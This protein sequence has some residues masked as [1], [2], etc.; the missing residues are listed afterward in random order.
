[1]AAEINI[2]DLFVTPEVGVKPPASGAVSYGGVLGT[3]AA[4][5]HE[6]VKPFVA[7]IEIDDMFVKQEPVSLPVVSPLPSPTV[8]SILS[9]PRGTG[10]LANP[11]NVDTSKFEPAKDPVA[12]ASIDIDDMFE[13]PKLPTVPRVS[14]S[15][16]GVLG[17]SGADV[18]TLAQAMQP[19]QEDP[20]SKMEQARI[21]SFNKT[22]Q[23][24]V[25]QKVDFNSTEQL[26]QIGEHVAKSIREDVAKKGDAASLKLLN[27]TKQLFGD[28]MWV[29]EDTH[30]ALPVSIMMSGVYN[31]QTA[32]E[33]SPALRSVL[34]DQRK[35]ARFLDLLPQGKEGQVARTYMATLRDTL[36]KYSRGELDDTTGRKMEEMFRSF[37]S[38]AASTLLGVFVAPAITPLGGIAVSLGANIALQ[39]AITQNVQ[40]GTT[41]GLELLGKGFSKAKIATIIRDKLRPEYVA[42]DGTVLRDKVLAAKSPA[43]GTGQATSPYLDDTFGRAALDVLTGQGAIMPRYGVVYNAA[44]L[45]GDLIGNALA[46]VVV[47]AVSPKTTLANMVIKYGAKVIRDMGVNVGAGSAVAAA[48]STDAVQHS[49]VSWAEEDDSRLTQIAKQIAPMFLTGAAGGKV[50]DAILSQAG[51]AGADFTVS[52]LAKTLSDMDSTNPTISKS[53]NAFAAFAKEFESPTLS[54]RQ[55]VR[56][57]ASA[58]GSG[59][60]PKDPGVQ[61]ETLINAYDYLFNLHGETMP[62]EQIVSWVDALPA[63]TRLAALMQLSELAAPHNVKQEFVVV[64]DADGQD[65]L[66]WQTSLIPEKTKF[67]VN[68]EAMS[69][70]PQRPTDLDEA[71]KLSTSP[72]KLSTDE[73]AKFVDI[74]SSGSQKTQ[75]FVD[76]VTKLSDNEILDKAFREAGDDP[77]RQKLVVHLLNRALSPASKKTEAGY[78]LRELMNTSDPATTLALVSKYTDSVVDPI[79]FAQLAVHAR[80]QRSTLQ[81]VYRMPKYLASVV[82]FTDN[83]IDTIK[84]ATYDTATTDLLKNMVQGLLV[85]TAAKYKDAGIP[86]LITKDNGVPALHEDHAAYVQ[87]Y[88]SK[89]PKFDS[90]DWFAAMKDLVATLKASIN[91]NMKDKTDQER[92]VPSIDVK[93]IDLPVDPQAVSQFGQLLLL[94]GLDKQVRS[95]PKQ[96]DAKTFVSK[97][98]LA[99]KYDEAKVFDQVKKIVDDYVDYGSASVYNRLKQVYGES[100]AVPISVLRAFRVLRGYGQAVEKNEMDNTL[101]VSLAKIRQ[102][103]SFHIIPE[104]YRA[105]FESTPEGVVALRNGLVNTD[106]I[107]HN[108]E[109][110]LVAM[111]RA[112]DIIRREALAPVY[113]SGLGPIAPITLLNNASFW[114]SKLTGD[115]VAAAKG[116]VGPT[117]LAFGTSPTLLKT[118][119]NALTTTINPS[120]VGMLL[121]T[122]AHTS[123]PAGMAELCHLPVSK[124][125]V[126]VN[127]LLLLDPEMSERFRVRV[128]DILNTLL[129]KDNIKKYES[130]EPFES[131]AKGTGSIRDVSLSIIGEYINQFRDTKTPGSTN[132]LTYAAQYLS[133]HPNIDWRALTTDLDMRLKQAYMDLLTSQREFDLHGMQAD[134]LQ[135]VN[136]HGI[137]ELMKV[138][139]LSRQFQYAVGHLT[140]HLED[141]DMPHLRKMF[142]APSNATKT[143][144]I[145]RINDRAKT[146]ASATLFQNAGFG[147]KEALTSSLERNFFTF[148]GAQF[149][150]D[151]VVALDTYNEL[152]EQLNQ[153]IYDPTTA[154][155]TP[156]AVKGWI[157]LIDKLR[158]IT[159]TLLGQDGSL[160]QF[161]SLEM[162]ELLRK[163]SLNGLDIAYDLLRAFDANPKMYNLGFTTLQSAM[164]EFS[165]VFDHTYG[166]LDIFMRN[167][168][169]DSIAQGGSLTNASVM[170]SLLEPLGQLANTGLM[171]H[172]VKASVYQLGR[173]T[174]YKKLT[175]RIAETWHNLLASPRTATV[176]R[177]LVAPNYGYSRAY[178]DLSMQLSR[179]QDNLDSQVQIIQ[180]QLVRNAQLPQEFLST[181]KQFT[182][183]DRDT[184]VAYLTTIFSQAD[185]NTPSAAKDILGQLGSNN[186]RLPE[187]IQ[188]LSV[189][190]ASTPAMKSYEDLANQLG[191]KV[192]WMADNDKYHSF[193]DP[194]TS[195]M[196]LSLRNGQSWSPRY[197]LGHELIHRMQQ[198][199]PRKFEEFMNT[200]FQVSAKDVQEFRDR[201][202]QQTGT[203][204][205]GTDR[206][207]T[208][209]EVKVEMLAR[210][211]GELLAQPDFA[212]V[213]NPGMNK[214][215]ADT[216]AME[217]G[218]PAPQ[219]SAPTRLTSG[220]QDLLHSY[221]DV[222]RRH[223]LFGFEDVQDTRSIQRANQF[224]DL[225]SKYSSAGILDVF[226]TAMLSPLQTAVGKKIKYSALMNVEDF[227]ADAKLYEDLIRNL[228]A[229]IQGKPQFDS[230]SPQEVAKLTADLAMDFTGSILSSATSDLNVLGMLERTSPS[231]AVAAVKLRAVMS[232]VSMHAFHE[233]QITA[234]DLAENPDYLPWQYYYAGAA[235]KQ[236][237]MESP[238][239]VNRMLSLLRMY[240]KNYEVQVKSKV[241]DV[242]STGYQELLYAKDLS[243]TA[244]QKLSADPENAKLQQ[245]E[246]E[247]TLSFE[248]RYE[249]MSKDIASAIVNAPFIV[250]LLGRGFYDLVNDVSTTKVAGT[251]KVKD[252]LV[253]EPSF[254]PKNVAAFMPRV[255]AQILDP[256]GNMQKSLKADDYD[257]LYKAL[258]GEVFHAGFDEWFRSMDEFLTKP[259][260]EVVR[261]DL[262][263][264]VYNAIYQ[265]DPQGRTLASVINSK[266]FSYASYRTPLTEGASM[267]SGGPTLRPDTNPSL[268]ATLKFTMSRKNMDPSYRDTLW[269]VTNPFTLI[270]KAVHNLSRAS[271]TMRYSATLMEGTGAITILP[272]EDQFIHK[273]YDSEY[274]HKATL[275]DIALQGDVGE[276][277][278][279]RI[280]STPQ[281]KLYL[282]RS[283]VRRL[284]SMQGSINPELSPL[285]RT[286]MSSVLHDKVLGETLEAMKKQ[287]NLVVAIDRNFWDELTSLTGSKDVASDV[288]LFGKAVPD[289]MKEPM[290]MFMTGLHQLRF[291]WQTN[292][293]IQNVPSYMRNLTG[294]LVLPVMTLGPI[295]GIRYLARAMNTM[296]SDPDPSSADYRYLLEMERLRKTV[297]TGSLRYAIKETTQTA[298]PRKLGEKIG[299]ALGGGVAILPLLKLTNW[300]GSQVFRGLFKAPGIKQV[301]ERYGMD[302]SSSYS[303]LLS[304][305]RWYSSIDTLTNF[306]VY[307][308]AREGNVRTP[309]ILA[310]APTRKLP[311]KF[312]KLDIGEGNEFRAFREGKSPKMTPDEAVRY[313][314]RFCFSYRD[315]PQ[316]IRAATLFW[317]P[318]LG[319]TYNAARIMK[320]MVSAYPVR[321][322]A[323]FLALEVL[324]DQLEDS[325]GVDL[326]L[327]YIIPGYNIAQMT[328]DVVGLGPMDDYPD[329]DPLN[330]GAP[331]VKLKQMLTED[332]DP[333]TGEEYASPNWP[334]QLKNAIFRSMV[335][336]PA[337]PDLVVRLAIQGTNSLADKLFAMSVDPLQLQRVM[338]EVIPQSWSSKKVIENTILGKPVDR[339]MTQ[340]GN[341]AGIMYM[342]G[343]NLKVQD[344]V[345]LGAKLSKAEERLR[346]L[347]SAKLRWLY[348]SE[349]ETPQDVE[350]KVRGID[351]EIVQVQKN[352]VQYVKSLGVPVPPSLEDYDTDNFIESLANVI[353]TTL[354]EGLGF[355]NAPPG[356]SP[357]RR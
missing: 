203:V 225:L 123:L 234:K 279:R 247:A 303:T 208:D 47:A 148:D 29:D 237:S 167:L 91:S 285:Q 184:A 3:S 41:Y 42:D 61:R 179:R 212:F 206:V 189:D 13:Q 105:V 154:T 86:Y 196:Y 216:D 126:Q 181:L 277:L 186:S 262:T 33:M 52:A 160:A 158:T 224:Y 198:Q 232:T 213:N 117:L 297:E 274:Y 69:L 252:L 316:A 121:A 65:K 164:Q 319:F 292:V 253:V 2:D 170:H 103:A 24:F 49:L 288:S 143:D 16:S 230:Q 261:Y 32:S 226:S 219:L 39:Q 128:A 351:K 43:L 276:W 268:E 162:G 94:A 90:D 134:A 325:Y 266:L 284:A 10:T 305:R 188:V 35:F 108:I 130:S 73:Y 38:E 127:K 294:A 138:H 175:N 233:G 15:S 257:A 169:S 336:M 228:A 78:V 45:Q 221:F 314:D 146:F 176:A 139:T 321:T 200:R 141:K 192:K 111:Q 27:S 59:G 311:S 209:A 37:T 223:T 26:M 144:I 157:E 119:A 25:D 122:L 307:M 281:Y 193:Y 332:K 259:E 289:S 320:N 63:T 330:W 255:M 72:V 250:R 235:A 58:E 151:S 334:T 315:V 5:I 220:V 82:N 60:A 113:Y 57:V 17:V 338:D 309:D 136:L 202:L 244:K 335:P 264:A 89:A 256:S 205:P 185:K 324:K 110:S 348:T 283:M 260:Y 6:T 258:Q 343:F 171:V 62:R 54:L 75:Q 145:A 161:L 240:L 227:Q 34:S 349:Y 290:K 102:L 322:L 172:K 199:N 135:Y 287:G 9:N 345:V 125:Q 304:L 93:L 302:S 178:I 8:D 241:V 306:A 275:N 12:V 40:N 339:Y 299:Y 23:T 354:A 327:D 356:W 155:I 116:A 298:S 267:K 118:V 174:G 99:T 77:A 81:S 131:R 182:D 168:I 231:L 79:V 243:D 248:K 95:I 98:V 300:A 88:V 30:T 53:I 156:E 147:S 353:Q 142:A 270:Q 109:S 159:S 97:F 48:Y 229:A 140:R 191:I 149:V 100:G 218:H 328:A 215:L 11:R 36:G 282:Y 28:G 269:V 76:A 84:Q 112:G 352:M 249:K 342:L 245:Q 106:I 51:K 183:M 331:I 173:L 210:Y 133:R 326:N 166:A 67:T 317:N 132:A 44:S 340:Q 64:R 31:A 87:T 293:L 239:V 265:Q 153:A 190:S 301:V 263:K 114:L 291:L 280:Q 246:Q 217:A 92:S 137:L 355:N 211:A 150:K 180:E 329:L 101:N 207:L 308:A 242:I 115:D 104:E 124:L 194:S 165:F 107:V 21:N 318:F 1:M 70:F 201:V 18:G 74:L 83:L 295:N 197:Q 357:L 187:D 236:K 238:V 337:T 50:A 344:Q 222:N 66:R 272:E 350:R 19:K 195:T 313:M 347:E 254:N 85:H 341:L 22:M 4:E 204:L 214:F 7:P 251:D 71:G 312:T 296:L 96:V 152:K 333:F 20:T 323:S 286:F 177:W 46:N 346:S 278:V 310:F 68:S 80:D 55:P 56:V 271:S 120:K 273:L 129:S 163:R 14:D